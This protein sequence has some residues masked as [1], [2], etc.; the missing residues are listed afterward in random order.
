MGILK[1]ILS[2]ILYQNYQTHI[3]DKNIIPTYN[4]YLKTLFPESFYPNVRCLKKNMVHYIDK[5][6]LECTIVVHV[7]QKL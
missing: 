1:T 2:L 4:R 6:A 7:L 5:A 3:S